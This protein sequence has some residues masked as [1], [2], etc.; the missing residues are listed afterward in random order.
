[1]GAAAQCGGGRASAGPVS[2]SVGWD[3]TAY[4]IRLEGLLKNMARFLPMETFY[5]DNKNKIIIRVKL[6]NRGGFSICPH[7]CPGQSS[8]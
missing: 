2:S 6:V 7:N 1:M 8:G 3:R 4:L 5:Y